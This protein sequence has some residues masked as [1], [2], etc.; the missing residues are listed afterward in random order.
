MSFNHKFALAFAAGVLFAASAGAAETQ[1]VQQSASATVADLGG[2]A[3]ALTY[4]VDDA[5][6]RHV[7]TTVDTVLPDQTGRG[8]DRHA[9]VKFSTVLQ[10]GQVQT[11]S[12]PAADAAQAQELQIRRSGNGI[13]VTRIS[14]T[15]E[16]GRDTPALN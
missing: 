14:S 12:I 15:V 16:A 3:S 6:G 8:E 13:E 4:W 9:V 10:P 1:T 2:G 11:V 7:V 5:D